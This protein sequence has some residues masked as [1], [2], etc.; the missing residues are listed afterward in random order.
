MKFN[1]L[2]KFTKNDLNL[3][4]NFLVTIMAEVKIKERSKIGEGES[5]IQKSQYFSCQ[6]RS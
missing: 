5:F 3:L 4:G 6:K 1:A 2:T